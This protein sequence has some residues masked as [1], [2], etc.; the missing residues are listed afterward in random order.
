[1]ALPLPYIEAGGNNALAV[2][3]REERN[4]FKMLCSCI[5]VENQTDRTDE[6]ELRR[7]KLLQGSGMNARLAKAMQRQQFENILVDQD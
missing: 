4:A 6:D 3:S 5:L 2:S 7:P 1:M